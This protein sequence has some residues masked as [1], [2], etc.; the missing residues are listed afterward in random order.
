MKTIHTSKANVN[1]NSDT[2]SRKDNLSDLFGISISEI[3]P[4]FDSVLFR[5]NKGKSV[6]RESALKSSC[7]CPDRFKWGELKENEDRKRHSHFIRCITPYPKF[8]NTLSDMNLPC[9]TPYKAELTVDIFPANMTVSDLQLWID[10]FSVDIYR[11]LQ[12]KIISESREYKKAI[13][14]TDEKFGYRTVYIGKNPELVIY[15][16]HSKLN[17]KPCI[18]LEL[19]FD[20][21]AILEKKLCIKS[22]RDFTKID[23]YQAFES[24]LMKDFSFLTGQRL[25]EKSLDYFLSYGNKGRIRPYA[26]NKTAVWIHAVRVTKHIPYGIAGDLCIL[27]KIHS[28]LKTPGRKSAYKQRLLKARFQNFLLADKTLGQQ[29]PVYPIDL[30][31][32]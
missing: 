24:I 8:F 16:R 12:K 22:V 27:Q 5:L 7:Y 2:L 31:D 6:R 25:N 14:L 9:I 23:L 21:P 4:H 1:S 13:T 19:R 29:E 28:K 18:H 10:N 20:N 26:V 11:N 17:G 3:I 15:V 30:I 32:G